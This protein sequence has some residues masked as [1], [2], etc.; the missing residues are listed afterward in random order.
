MMLTTHALVGALLAL[1][2][3]LIAPAHAPI[4]VVAGFVGGSFP[5]LDVL[6]RHRRTLHFPRYY[7]YVALPAV[8]LALAYP[9][10]ATVGVALFL[11]GAWA[12]SLMDVVGGSPEPRPWEPT[13]ER[14]VYDHRSKRWLPPLRWIRYDGAP[15][16]LAL[17]LV[18]AVPVTYLAPEGFVY[19][20]AVVLV[21]SAVY[22]L[23]RKRIGLLA[24]QADTSLV[25]D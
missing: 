25:E 15:E 23:L 6:A 20:V 12:H 1:P 24:E 3:A 14:A 2:V 4:A 11:V 10:T 7:G 19:V 21:V 8:A 16:D 13:L 18:V 22:T 5:D 9:T 17:V